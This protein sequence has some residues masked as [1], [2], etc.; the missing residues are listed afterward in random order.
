MSALV[1]A[2]ALGQTSES[3]LS[4]AEAFA[5]AGGLRAVGEK[6]FFDA[7][8]SASGRVACATCH[9]PDHAFGPADGRAVQLGG[10]DGRQPGL[11]AVPSLKYLQVVPQ[12]TEH[13]HESEDDG[14]ASVDNGPTGGL[15]W[16]GRIDRGR[17]Q[18]RLPLF[19][20]F[21]MANDS[22][23]AL[24]A[25][26]RQAPY[27]DEL[28][29][30]VGV[31]RF[32]DDEGVVAG[33]TEALEVFEQDERFYPYSSKYDAYLAGRATLSPQEAR[34]LALFNDPAKGHC[35]NC[36]RSER[37]GNATPP[38]FTDY[39][40]IAIGVP[41]NRDI[42]ANADPEF[43]DLG[44]CGPLRT[45]LA[46]RKDYCGFFKTPTLR[47]VALRRTFFHNGFV[48]SLR[49]AIAFYVERD[50]RPDNWYP[51]DLSGNVQ[52]FD[53]LPAAY[54]GNVNNEPPFGARDDNRPALS[55]SE[56]DDIVAFLQTLTDGYAAM[57]QRKIE[58]DPHNLRQ[59]EL[60]PRSQGLDVSG[61]EDPQ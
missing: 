3:G 5:R 1:T 10:K 42:P 46:G 55:P 44:A 60:V 41:R 49:E 61:G 43:F 26:V 4:R 19:S 59:L 12:F 54:Q 33:I 11:R 37:S 40:L 13:Y 24:A 35:N 36:H 53:D 57:P 14:D 23:T 18:A 27:A 7:S 9:H 15:T 8:L 50:T 29:K 48:H 56:I 34:G 21:E 22:S 58:V 47:N 38:Q 30:I 45:D 6:I 2:S 25:R 28:R 32:A 51:R 20:P 17:D 52:K 16:D 31:H 39:G